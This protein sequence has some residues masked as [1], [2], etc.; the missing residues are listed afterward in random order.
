MVLGRILSHSIYRQSDKFQCLPEMYWQRY[1]NNTWSLFCQQRVYIHFNRI[2][3]IVTSR[4][5][6]YIFSV[7][8]NWILS[9]GPLKNP[10]LNINENVWKMMSD[11]IYEKQLQYIN[12]DELTWAMDN[13]GIAS[14]RWFALKLSKTCTNR[15]PNNCL[16]LL[17]QRKNISK[18]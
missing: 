3:A 10:N 18:Y 15:Y 13:A 14:K 16:M 11:I 6:R 2:F 8:S 12:L 7:A 4:H 9:I 17:V 5:Q 1:Q